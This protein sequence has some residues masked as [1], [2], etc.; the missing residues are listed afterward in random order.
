MARDGS[1][2]MARET[3]ERWH[4]DELVYPQVGWAGAIARDAQESRAHG[5][6]EGQRGDSDSAGCVTIG[7]A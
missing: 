7:V 5:A 1:G 3:R 2:V 6:A 4:V